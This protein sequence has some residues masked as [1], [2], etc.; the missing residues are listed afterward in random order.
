MV[1]LL[2]RIGFQLSIYYII[3]FYTHEVKKLKTTQKVNCDAKA[4]Q[5][6]P[7]K[8]PTFFI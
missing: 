1:K 2:V 5:Y 4:P 6:L 7:Y 3:I 8:K